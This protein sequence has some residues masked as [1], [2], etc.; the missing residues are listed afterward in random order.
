MTLYRVALG[1]VEACCIAIK[2]VPA[3]FGYHAVPCYF[4]RSRGVLI[5]SSNHVP[6]SLWPELEGVLL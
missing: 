3:S 6:G 1:R 5:S 4:G 2:Y